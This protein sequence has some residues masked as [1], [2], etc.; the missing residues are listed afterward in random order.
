V[1]DTGHVGL[2]ELHA[3]LQM[4]FAGHVWVAGL[5]PAAPAA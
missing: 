4:V 2:V 3:T 1:D 5:T